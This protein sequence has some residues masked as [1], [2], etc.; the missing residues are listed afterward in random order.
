MFSV[1]LCSMFYPVP[2]KKRLHFPFLQF[3]HTHICWTTFILTIRLLKMH[4]FFSRPCKKALLN[5]VA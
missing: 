1:A 2:A 4:N 5:Q 3:T